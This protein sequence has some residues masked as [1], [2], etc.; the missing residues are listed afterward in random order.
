M[1][2]QTIQ[3]TQGLLKEVKGETKIWLTNI[4]V[5]T[6]FSAVSDL[7]VEYALAL[8]RRYDARLYVTHMS[9][10]DAYMRAEHGLAELTYQQMGQA[11]E[12][13]IAD[14]LISG[15]LRG[16]PHE[17]LLYEGALWPTVERL[18]EVQE[19]DLVVTG[20]HGRGDMKKVVIGSVAEEGFRQAGCTGLTV[21]PQGR[22]QPPQGRGLKCVFFASRLV[23][24]RARTA[25]HSLLLPHETLPPS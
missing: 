22:E 4:M 5:L 11:A 3:P 15:K 16:V 17:V 21:G 20:T 18:I 2:T 7:A 6:D 14:I 25:P 9:S 19:I 12:Q 8:A 24:E 10:P 23:A 1:S 13:S